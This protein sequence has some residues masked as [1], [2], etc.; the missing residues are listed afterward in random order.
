[1]RNL[2]DQR[3]LRATLFLSTNMA[4][5]EIKQFVAFWKLTVI[6]GETNWF[7][8]FLFFPPVPGE[9]LGSTRERGWSWKTIN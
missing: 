9:G 4:L 7:A 3:S 1:M 8:G 2:Y 6:Q 5:R